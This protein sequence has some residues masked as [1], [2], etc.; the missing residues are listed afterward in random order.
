MSS[1]TTIGV[2]IIGADWWAQTEH[3]PVLQSLGEEF[4]VVAVSSRHLQTA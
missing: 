4:E 3:I 2:G 1:S